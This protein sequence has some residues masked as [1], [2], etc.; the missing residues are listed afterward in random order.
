MLLAQRAKGPSTAVGR[1]GF[2]GGMHEVGETILTAAQREL[3]EETGVDAMPRRVIDAFDVIGRDPDGRIRA[4]YVL[5]CVVLDWVATQQLQ[6]EVVH[7]TE[8]EPLG[9][10]GGI[11][12]A[13][14]AAT[15]RN[16]AVLNGDTM[17]Q[18]PLGKLRTVSGNVA[19]AADGHAVNLG[20]VTLSPQD[21][22]EETRSTEIEEDGRFRFLYVPAG[23]YVLR[24]EDAADGESKVQLE[25]GDNVQVRV[26]EY[27]KAEVA[28][29]V[30]E[31]AAST[32]IAVPERET[33]PTQ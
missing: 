22:P 14:R 2:P 13:L 29:H 12:L 18:V 8:A 23:D 20:T 6:F 16:V 30:G 31:E 33:Q 15:A 4:H 5:V 10:G 7:V 26:H 28:V 17:F 9:T 25:R 24:T 27:G 11:L 21:D 3:S 1:W 19:A 32:T